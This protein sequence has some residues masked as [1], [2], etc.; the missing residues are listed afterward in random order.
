[1]IIAILVLLFGGVFWRLLWGIMHLAVNL[2]IFILVVLGIVWL[3][4]AVSSD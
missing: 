4:R 2:L 3:V 1:M